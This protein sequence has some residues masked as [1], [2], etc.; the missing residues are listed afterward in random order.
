[1][2]NFNLVP[3]QH[4]ATMTL[5]AGDVASPGDV[6]TDVTLQLADAAQLVTHTLEPDVQNYLNYEVDFDIDTKVNCVY[7]ER[8][9]SDSLFTMDV[10]DDTGSPVLIDS[11]TQV[12]DYLYLNISTSSISKYLISLHT[13]ATAPS[14]V[15][16]SPPFI[17]GTDLAGVSDYNYK[18]GRSYEFA[19]TVTFQR[20]KTSAYPQS[21]SQLSKTFSIPRVRS[22]H[23]QYYHEFLARN[24]AKLMLF[25]AHDEDSR[26]NYTLGYLSP[27]A[28]SV[29]DNGHVF[30][31]SIEF[32]NTGSDRANTLSEFSAPF[33]PDPFVPTL[34][35]ASHIDT[36]GTHATYGELVGTVDGVETEFTTSIGSYDAGT[37]EVIYRGAQQTDFVETNA[38]TGLVTIGF[39][40]KDSSQDNE[41]IIKYEKT[42]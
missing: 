24:A 34:V 10:Y 9:N 4:N 35:K 20:T 3:A 29:N 17:G 30:P 21:V 5:I 11:T 7:F 19:D 41:L 38:A 18:N 13:T 32:K 37:V 39:S 12:D 14:T 26:H 8:I 2:S 15:T 6:T 16:M 1:M 28:S 33:V 40:P 31:F 22:E 36:N 42:T 27:K 23:S 25:R